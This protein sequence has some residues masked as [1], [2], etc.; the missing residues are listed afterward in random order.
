MYWTG[1]PTTAVAGGAPWLRLDMMRR[2]NG[3]PLAKYRNIVDLTRPK[4]NFDAKKTFDV[5][6]ELASVTP[7]GVSTLKAMDKITD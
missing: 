7:I 6:S 4:K 5:V 1:L 3:T 2:F